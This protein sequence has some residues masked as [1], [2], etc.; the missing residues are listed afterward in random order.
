[1]GEYAASNILDPRRDTENPAQGLDVSCLFLQ[2]VSYPS[3]IQYLYT[4]SWRPAVVYPQTSKQPFPSRPSSRTR[5]LR[6]GLA[7]PWTLNRDN[8]TTTTTTKITASTQHRY[9]PPALSTCPG[10]QHMPARLNQHRRNS[11]RHSKQYPDRTFSTRAEHTTHTRAP[12]AIIISYPA[13]ASALTALERRCCGTAARRAT[14]GLWRRTWFGFQLRGGNIATLYRRLLENS[15]T[16]MQICASSIWSS[17]YMCP[18]HTVRPASNPEIC[19]PFAAAREITG[20][21][22]MTFTEEVLMTTCTEAFKLP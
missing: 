11:P 1:V 2:L 12:L 21:R 6:G 5:A 14:A 18:T 9:R 3:P 19:I 8:T 22:H 16:N 7:L 10:T 4:K 20:A 17:S 13:S 15:H